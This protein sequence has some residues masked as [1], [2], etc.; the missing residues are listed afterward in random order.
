MLMFSLVL[1]VVAL[2]TFALREVKQRDGW[3]GVFLFVAFTLFMSSC[4][5]TILGGP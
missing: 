1:L 3:V 4:T 5:A 2:A